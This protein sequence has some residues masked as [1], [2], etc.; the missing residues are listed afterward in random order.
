MPRLVLEHVE[1]ESAL[2]EGTAYVCQTFDGTSCTDWL[3][4]EV[5]ER[6]HVGGGVL[7]PLSIQASAEIL[8]AALVVLAIAWG[9]RQILY[10]MG[11]R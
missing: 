10:T 5:Q 1:G 3:V 6:P 7:P 2:P 9:I 4:V 8:A 11:V